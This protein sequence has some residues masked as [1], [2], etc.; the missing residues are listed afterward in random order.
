VL[1]ASDNQADIQ[2]IDPVVT[3]EVLLLQVAKVRKAA[4]RAARRGDIAEARILFNQAIN[5]LT[6]I[7]ADQRE[8]NELI[9]LSQRLE[10]FTERDM[11]AQYSM[12]R[13]TNKG[14][15]KRFD[16]ND[17]FNH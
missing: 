6:T 1:N 15:G 4:I 10:Q 14:R 13:S 16:P 3:R 12:L 2:E 9:D 17:P 8:I 11:K 7:G 5:V